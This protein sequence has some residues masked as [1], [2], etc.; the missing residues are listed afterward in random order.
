MLKWGGGQ[1]INITHIGITS[2]LFDL[3]CKYNPDV[4]CLD[5]SNTRSVTPI[6]VML[7]M[8]VCECIYLM[9]YVTLYYGIFSDV[10]VCF[11]YVSTGV[12]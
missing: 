10:F 6:Y 12:V 11:S 8:I 7:S 9:Q 3:E 4:H 1:N 2:A 5:F